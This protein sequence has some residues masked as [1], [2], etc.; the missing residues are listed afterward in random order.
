MDRIDIHIEVP[1]VPFQELSSAQAGTS[2]ATMRES[3]EAARELQAVRFAG[4]SIYKAQMSSR[5]LRELC[6]LNRTCSN[7][8]REDR[9]RCHTPA[10]PR[11]ADQIRKLAG[12]GTVEF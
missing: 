8:P 5:P 1:A 2:S 12:S 7:L 9:R 4:E 6:P 11:L 3:V 10:I